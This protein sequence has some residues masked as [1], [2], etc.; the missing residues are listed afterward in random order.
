[1]AS[2][3]MR[4]IRTTYTVLAFDAEGRLDTSRFVKQ[5]FDRV[6]GGSRPPPVPTERSVR[7]SRTTLF[8]S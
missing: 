7:I 3:A 2:E 1:M 5:Q 8:S 4:V 6:T